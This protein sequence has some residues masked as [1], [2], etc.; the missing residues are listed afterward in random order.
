MFYSGKH[1]ITFF[2]KDPMTSENEVPSRNT[3]DDWKLIPTSKPIIAPPEVNSNLTYIPGGSGFYNTSEILTG[4]PTYKSRTGELE[5]T[6]LNAYNNDTSLEWNK[7]YN[8]ISSFLHGKEMKCVLEDDPAYYYS[9][10]FSVSSAKSGGYNSTI[11]IKYEVQPFK[12]ARQMCDEDWLWDPF[13]FIDGVITNSDYFM[14][15]PVTQSQIYDKYITDLVGD[16]PIVPTFKIRYFNANTGATE[17][18]FTATVVITDYRGTVTT[19]TTLIY[20]PDD[21]VDNSFEYT[22]PLFVISKG[23]SVHLTIVPTGCSAEVGYSFREGKI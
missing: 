12:R 6:V 20:P 15:R 3:F 13:D 2:Y 11:N 10:V 23:D 1:T 21:M 9:G 16:E 19:R 4:Y 7:V 17:P 14:P 22:D 8:D 18:H 5:F